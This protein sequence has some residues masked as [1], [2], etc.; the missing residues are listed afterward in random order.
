MVSIL[1]SFHALVIQP[2]VFMF[3]I[4]MLAYII[5]GWLAATGN[6]SPYK[7]KGVFQVYTVLHNIFEPM[8]APV[9]RLIPPLGGTLDLSP[10]VILL[11]IRFISDGL[12]PNLLRM[13]A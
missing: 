8:F 11:G 2:V 1:A 3:T 13:M 6:V 9:R 5:V 12:I 4:A 7:N 10:I